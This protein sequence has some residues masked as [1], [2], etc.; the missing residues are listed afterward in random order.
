RDDGLPPDAFQVTAEEWLTLRRKGWSEAYYSRMENALKANAY[1][2]FGRA[3]IDSITGKMVLDAMLVVQAR[4]ARDMAE[5]VLSAIGSVFRYAAGTGRVRADV[6][7]GLLDFLDEKPPV[8]HFP[9]VDIGTLPELLRRV[10]NYHGRP[11]TR[12]AI[13]IMMRTFPRTNELRWGNGLRCAATE[14]YG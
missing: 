6:T 3:R 2:H 11:K 4:G 13:M 14:A 9:H 7:P 5:R 12:L 1:P 10:E 8:R